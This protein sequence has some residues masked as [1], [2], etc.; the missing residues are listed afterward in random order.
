MEL[1]VGAWRPEYLTAPLVPAAFQQQAAACPNSPCLVSEDGSVLTFAQAD[2]AASALAR[3]LVAR[4]V[5]RD[6]AVGILLDRSPAVVVSML[7][8]HKVCVCVSVFSEIA[9]AAGVLFNMCAAGLLHTACHQDSCACLSF[10]CVCLS[11]GTGWWL[12]R[13]PGPQ[14]PS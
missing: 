14:L 8:I 12:L 2:A 13:A 4:G 11:V 10:V 1:C 7:A 9:A 5:G 6:M 3:R